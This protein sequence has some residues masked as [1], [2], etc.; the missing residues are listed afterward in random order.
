M[1]RVRGMVNVC[2]MCTYKGLSQIILISGTT[3]W[4]ERAPVYHVC[5]C[6]VSGVRACIGHT[7][8]AVA[9]NDQ[10]EREG[11]TCKMSRMNWK[12]GEGWWGGWFR[13][14]GGGDAYLS[15]SSRRFA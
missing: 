3:W 11:R 10:R 6:A 5:S 12:C 9:E 2:V 13:V 14:C 4:C 15:M 7:F 1:N 8:A